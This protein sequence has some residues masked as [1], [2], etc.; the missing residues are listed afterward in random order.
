M[1]AFQEYNKNEKKKPHLF[2]KDSKALLLC[3]LMCGFG[4]TDSGTSGT[5]GMKICC[6]LL[7][8]LDNFTL[9]ILD[10]RIGNFCVLAYKQILFI[11]LSE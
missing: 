1:P 8:L 4:G 11:L 3:D 10:L 9:I 6:A 2:W 7:S 5:I